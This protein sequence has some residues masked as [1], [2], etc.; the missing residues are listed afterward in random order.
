MSTFD[1]SDRD[2]LV[3]AYL[4]GEATEAERAVVEADP[5]L[6][7]RAELLRQVADLVAEPVMS[8]PAAVRRDHIAAALAASPTAANVTS[9]ATH[10]RRVD[11]AK[12]ASIAAVVLAV[13]AVPI[14][15][16]QNAGDD[17][18]DSVAST[19][20]EEPAGLD[21]LDAGAS[22]AVAADADDAAD[23]AAGDAAAP[24]ATPPTAETLAADEPADEAA[25]EETEAF[26]GASDASGD[27]G[28]EE[29]EA[30]PSEDAAGSGERAVAIEARFDPP[31]VADIDQLADEVLGAVE[32]GDIAIDPEVTDL[33]QFDCIGEFLTVDEAVGLMPGVFAGRATLA[34][35]PVE[36]L[37]G[38]SLD[39][40]VLVVLDADCAVDAVEILG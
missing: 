36:Y 14:V 29:A 23:D 11:I 18:D 28:A 25:V 19:A 20:A 40:L 24:A 3:A 39:G 32:R 9:L 12:V 17:G 6:V 34:G 16:L 4:D 27:D 38:E 30:E 26:D 31:P 5:E 13:L 15:L 37:V 10:R 22:A 21:E 2:E 8:P 7:A 35:A 1:P 33:G